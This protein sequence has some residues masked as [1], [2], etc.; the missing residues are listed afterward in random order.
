MT[1]LIVGYVLNDATV[2]HMLRPGLCKPFEEY[3][4]KVF[5]PYLL[6]MLKTVSC[7]DVV[8]LCYNSYNII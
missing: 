8:E 1:K 2:V 7:V 4:T 5:I 6:S 3:R